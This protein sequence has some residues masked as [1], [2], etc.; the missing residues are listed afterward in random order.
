MNAGLLESAMSNS[1]V[2]GFRTHVDCYTSAHRGW[3]I[4]QTHTRKMRI[5]LKKSNLYCGSEKK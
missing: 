4:S 5:F 2:F 3:K 1:R